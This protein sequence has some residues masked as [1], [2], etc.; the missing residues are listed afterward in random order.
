MEKQRVRRL[1]AADYLITPDRVIPNGAVLCENERIIGV[2]GQSGFSV[3]PE[4]EL[5]HFKNA[6]I[7]PGFLDT[8]IHG[9]GGCDCSRCVSSPR[10]LAAMSKILGERGVTGFF[11]TVVADTKELMLENLQQLSQAMSS[12]LPGADAIA[13]NVEGPFLNT[14]RA[15]SQP[16]EVLCGIDAGFAKELIAA[17]NGLV[18]IMTFAPE[19]KESDKLI[20]LLCENNVIASMGHSLANE[21]QTLRAIDAGATHCTHLFNGMEPLHQRQV[22]LAGIALTDDRVTVELIID[23]R[24]VHSRMVDLACRCKPDNRIIGISDCTMAS[25]MPDG[26][27]RIGPSEIRVIGGFSQNADGKLAGTTTMLDSGWHSLMSC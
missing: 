7:A 15:G 26:D 17:G 20:S 16:H 19:L 9:A 13:I 6:Y 23:G 22:G 24:H 14:K 5:Y 12:P 27:Y 25:G 3:E 8:H 21:T 4:I 1:Y 18:K 11:P 10:D 2:G